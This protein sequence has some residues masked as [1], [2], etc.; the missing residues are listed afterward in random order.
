MILIFDIMAQNHVTSNM[1]FTHVKLTFCIQY[2]GTWQLKSTL[3]E[4]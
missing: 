2:Y 4:C 3:Q 1:I